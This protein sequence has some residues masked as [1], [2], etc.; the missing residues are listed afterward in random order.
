LT[1]QKWTIDLSVEWLKRATVFGVL[2]LYSHVEVTEVVGY[3][4]DDPKTPINV[5]SIAVLE[6]RQGEASTKPTFCTAK[7][8]SG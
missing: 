4:D 1:N 6:T 3:R 7:N 2:G 8:A 5:F